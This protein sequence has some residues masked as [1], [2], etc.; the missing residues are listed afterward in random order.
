MAARSGTSAGVVLACA[1]ASVLAP[2]ARAAGEPAAAASPDGEALFAATVEP[3]LA[4]RCLGCHGPD[5]AEG[6]LRLDLRAGWA[7]GGDSGPAILPGE[8]ER[9]LLVRAIRWETPA[10]QMPP[11]GRLSDEEIARVEAWV[12]QGAPDP[13]GGGL[14]PRGRNL[15]GGTAGMTPEEGRMLWSLRPLSL[16]AAPQVA[17]P[18][19]NEGPIDPFVRARL[20]STGFFPPP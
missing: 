1:V 16:P 19:W 18:A 12:R 15:P 2:A 8:P 3:L 11:D 13:R 9:S 7:E 17:D 20:A 4:A 10:P 5:E 14:P 6:G